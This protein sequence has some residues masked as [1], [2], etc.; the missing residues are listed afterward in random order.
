MTRHVIF[1]ENM[2]PYTSVHAVSV[3]PS[4]SPTTSS[5]QPLIFKSYLL[6]S[7]QKRK[8]KTNVFSYL[9]F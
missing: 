9:I 2:F 8:E 5:S 6:E 1:D 3:P 7:F 4:Q